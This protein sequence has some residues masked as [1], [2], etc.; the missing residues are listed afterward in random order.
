MKELRLFQKDLAE[1]I[2]VTP[3]AMG[4]YLSGRREPTVASLQ[5]IVQVL[6]VSIEL[7]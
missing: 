6:D 2:G 5:Q 4:D 3:S 1:E 7:F